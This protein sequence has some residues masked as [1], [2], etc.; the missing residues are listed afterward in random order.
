MAHKYIRG[1]EV[2]SSRPHPTDPQK[3]Q[4]RFRCPPYFVNEE[5]RVSV[6]EEMDASEY[7]SELYYEGPSK[8]R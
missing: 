7:R 8:P 5:Q 2:L 3:M 1:R 6:W 4:V